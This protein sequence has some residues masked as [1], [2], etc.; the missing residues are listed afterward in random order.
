MDAFPFEAQGQ[1]AIRGHGE[2]I[3]IYSVRAVE[4]ASKQA[5]PAIKLLDATESRA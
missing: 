4:A 3:N 5:D 1:S 2:P